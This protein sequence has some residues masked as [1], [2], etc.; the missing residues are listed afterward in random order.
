MADFFH[1]NIEINF[2]ELAP[3]IN[4]AKS[5]DERVLCIFNTIPDEVISRWP[6]QKIHDRLYKGKKL[7][8]LSL[9]RVLRNLSAKGYLVIVGKEKGEKGVGNYLY[10][11]NPNPPQCKKA[12]PKKVDVNLVFIDNP[13]GTRDLNYSEMLKTF[14][15]KFNSAKEVLKL[16]NQN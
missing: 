10:K 7:S 16:K 6:I 13:D 11:L 4:M 14:N 2:D 9:G 3:L 1:N 5:Q 12:L 15:A 8:D